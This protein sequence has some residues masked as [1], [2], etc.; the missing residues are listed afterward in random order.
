MPRKQEVPED[1]IRQRSYKIWEN[2][3]YP[4][5]HALEHWLQA[6]AELE[7]ALLSNPRPHDESGPVLPCPKAPSLPPTRVVA[8]SK[9]GKRKRGKRS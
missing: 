1:L 4:I 6:K 8:P 3:G 2:E 7:T 9:R 5:G